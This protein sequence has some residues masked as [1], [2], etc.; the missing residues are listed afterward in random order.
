MFDKV[1][2]YYRPLNVRD[3]VHMLKRGNGQGQIVAGATDVVVGN[4][5]SIRFLIDLSHAGLSY[6]QQKNGSW[7]IG[8]TVTMA[9]IENSPELRSLAGGILS[10]ASSTCGSMQ[11]RNAATV[12]GNL[13]NRSP[14]ADIAVPLLALDASVAIAGLGNRRR[15]PL[16]EYLDGARDRRFASTLIVEIAIPSPPEGPGGW[17]FQKLGRTAVDISL[18]NVA[19]G[20]QLDSKGRVSRARIALG[21]VAPTPI[22]I[23]AAEQLLTGQKLTAEL[24]AEASHIVASEVQPITDQRATADYRREM[25]RVLSRRALEE[26]G[27]KAMRSQLLRQGCL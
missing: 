20:L 5:R 11:I 14:A 22:R 4:D 7:V 3:A 2:A 1:E 25:S 19:A 6:I 18:V 10:R 26:C 23:Y 8:A 15:F 17:A 9:D 21:A 27:S 16:G 13:A 24:I 12:G